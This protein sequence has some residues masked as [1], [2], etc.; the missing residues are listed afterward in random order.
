MITATRRKFED[1][2][3]RQS[4]PLPMLL[5]RCLVL[6]TT[7]A[8]LLN[9]LADGA[10]P[11]KPGA[12]EGLRVSTCQFPSFSARVTRTGSRRTSIPNY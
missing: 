11:T 10:W 6:N 1:F 12:I 7:I 3:S 9:L 4:L 2:A 5:E 8:P